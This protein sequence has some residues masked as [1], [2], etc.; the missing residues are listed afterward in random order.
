MPA[1]LL[2]LTSGSFLVMWAKPVHYRPGSMRLRE[3]L[4]TILV[5]LAGP[6]ANAALAAVAAIALAVLPHDI[7]YAAWRALVAVL[8]VNI[9]LVALNMLPI[10]PLD[11]G[12]LWLLVPLPPKVRDI[13]AAAAAVALLAVVV[14]MPLATPLDPFGDMVGAA[15]DS[16]L[17]LAMDGH[18]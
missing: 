17:N 4:A 12:A 9:T 7:P 16:T 11:G 14:G 13:G 1:A 18:L 15:V 6:A 3:P 2:F 5:K 10:P 8:A